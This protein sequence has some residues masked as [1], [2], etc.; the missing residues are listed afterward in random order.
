MAVVIAAKRV[1]PI[2]SPLGLMDDFAAGCS[3][4]DLEGELFAES[5][6]LLGRH[7]NT[8]STDALHGWTWRG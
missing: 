4:P 2:P 8:A 6:L 1:S 7:F 3:R 5:A